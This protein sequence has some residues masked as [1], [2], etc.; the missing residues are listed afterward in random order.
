MQHRQPLFST[1]TFSS[2]LT[3]SVQMLAIYFG[4]IVS[5]CN[6]INST[7]ARNAEIN[8]CGEEKQMAGEVSCYSF[9]KINLYLCQKLNVVIPKN[10]GSQL[11]IYGVLRDPS[12]LLTIWSTF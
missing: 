3:E 7:F 12:I 4:S 8:L 1:A 6:S 11:M 2:K 5:C 9:H 10:Y